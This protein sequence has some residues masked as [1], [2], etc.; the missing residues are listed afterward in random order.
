LVI[1]NF[2]AGQTAQSIS[3]GGID[4]RPDQGLGGFLTKVTDFVRPKI[5]PDTG[6]PGFSAGATALAAAAAIP[7]IAGGIE[8]GGA[9]GAL[10][11]V[12]GA[13]GVAASIPGPQQPF[14]IAGALLTGFIGSFLKS[15]AQKKEE[16]LAAALNRKFELPGAIDVTRDLTGNAVD[17]N[18]RGELR[19]YERNGGTVVNV[20]ISAMDSK[21][22]FD[23]GPELSD[24]VMNM[25]QLNHP[26]RSQIQEIAGTT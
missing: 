2:A 25:L 17:Y 21:S 23:R 4:F 22:F 13:L 7:A 10:G 5:N 15:K 20:N 16:A 9:K 11:A 14:L 26:L 3:A 6:K 18:S 12:S 1:G 19:T 24:S 8:E